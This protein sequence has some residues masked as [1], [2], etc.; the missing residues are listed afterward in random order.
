MLA[1]EGLHRTAKDHRYGREEREGA[2]QNG[3]IKENDRQV[4]HGNCPEAALCASY[5]LCGWSL[6]SE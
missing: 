1:K 5:E 4:W 2:L 3:E 6:V